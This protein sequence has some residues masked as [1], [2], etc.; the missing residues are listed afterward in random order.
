MGMEGNIRKI[1][2]HKKKDWIE[3]GMFGRKMEMQVGC[4]IMKK[5]NRE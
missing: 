4:E 3:V 2:R 1:D 5:W